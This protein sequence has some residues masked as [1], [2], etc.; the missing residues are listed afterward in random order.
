[1]INKEFFEGWVK[2]THASY[3]DDPTDFDGKNPPCC[4]DGCEKDIEHDDDYCEDQW[5]QDSACCEARMSESGLCYSCKEHC[6]SSW[7]AA[8]EEADGRF[9]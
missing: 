5:S 8:V 4:I 7:E 3:G 9:K 2:A 1:M 6:C